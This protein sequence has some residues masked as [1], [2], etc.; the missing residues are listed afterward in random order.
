[1]GT[2][3]LPRLT[4][5]TQQAHTLPPTTQDHMQ[6][7]SNPDLMQHLSNQD[8]MQPRQSIPHI[9]ALSPSTVTTTTGPMT[10]PSCHTQ[11]HMQPQCHIQDHMQPQTT[12]D[13]MQ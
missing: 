5:T 11:H 7:H 12:R 4:P 9:T 6:P 13:L 3:W 2:P 8:R 10:A 1:M